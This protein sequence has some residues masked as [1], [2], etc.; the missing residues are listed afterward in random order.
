VSLALAR[1]TRLADWP[2]QNLTQTWGSP[3]RR[4]SAA[5]PPKLRQDMTDVHWDIPSVQKFFSLVHDGTIISKGCFGV[6]PQFLPV[7]GL[8]CS[9][10]WGERPRE[11]GTAGRLRS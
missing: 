11:P 5:R 10:W 2:P 4:Q 6:K 9:V 3:F 7:V 1:A 8:L